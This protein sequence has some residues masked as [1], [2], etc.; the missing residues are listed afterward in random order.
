MKGAA[1]LKQG[2]SSWLTISILLFK[3]FWLI[4]R[5]RLEEACSTL[6]SSTPACLS[7]AGS[8]TITAS[9]AFF[10]APTFQT[11]LFSFAVVR[12]TPINSLQLRVFILCQLPYMTALPVY[13]FSTSCSALDPSVP[14]HH[15]LRLWDSHSH[16]PSPRSPK[17]RWAEPHVP[18]TVHAMFAGREKSGFVHIRRTFSQG[19]P[20]DHSLTTTLSWHLIS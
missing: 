1:D 12:S 14:W 7:E 5:G 9:K 19:W 15:A 2:V 10:Q 20:E 4:K 16:T 18:P 6:Q 8:D 13:Q 11:C 3:C 17:S